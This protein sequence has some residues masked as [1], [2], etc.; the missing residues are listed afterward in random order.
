MSAKGKGKKMNDC[1]KQDIKKHI[2]NRFGFAM[3]KIELLECGSDPFVYC[4]FRVCDIVYQ[5]HNDSLHI[6]TY[7]DQYTYV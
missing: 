1:S 2:A 3:N 4:M 6:Y 5:A 7:N